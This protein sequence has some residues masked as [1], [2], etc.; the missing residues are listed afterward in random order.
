MRFGEKSSQEQEME[1]A[2]KLVQSTIHT[3]MS[4]TKC[5]WSMAITGEFS[6]RHREAAI[7]PPASLARFPAYQGHFHYVTKRLP[8]LVKA[9]GYQPLLCFHA[10]LN[11]AATM[12][13]WNIKRGFMSLGKML[14][15]SG[16]QCSLHTWRLR[17]NHALPIWWP[18]MMGWLQQSTQ[19]DQHTSPT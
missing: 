10:G 15:G 3:R 2:T 5:A 18:S 12:R 13:L 6:L 14:K 11:K 16:T 17:G 4:A 8:R 7:Y 1:N 9:E 19:E